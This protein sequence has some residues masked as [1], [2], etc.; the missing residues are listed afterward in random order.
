MIFFY[1]PKILK[2][3][4]ETLEKIVKITTTTKNLKTLETLCLIKKK[5]RNFRESLKW[6][7]NC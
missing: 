6:S 3:S 2:I 1:S 7:I 5:T 4:L